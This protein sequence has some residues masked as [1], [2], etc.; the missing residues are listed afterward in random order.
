MD[1]AASNQRPKARRQPFNPLLD[2][3]G[4]GLLMTLP[5]SLG[6]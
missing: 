2:S 5:T 4:E 3:I 1:R 6:V